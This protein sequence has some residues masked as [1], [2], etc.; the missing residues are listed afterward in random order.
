MAEIMQTIDKHKNMVLIGTAK[1]NYK[2]NEV[3]Y[4]D[5][6]QAVIESYGECKLTSA[7][8]VA[9]GFGVEN[10]FLINVKRNHDYFD[11]VT[12]LKHNDFTYIVPVNLF[13]SDGY[14]DAYH[15]NKRITYFQYILEEIG[16]FNDSTLIVTDKH[17]SL[18]EDLDG[19]IGEM[20]ELISQF[21]INSSKNLQGQNLI[22]VANNLANYP[23]AN[24]VLASAL[25]VCD[26]D[27]Y[28]TL[29]FGPAIFNIDTFD[30]GSELAFFKNNSIAETSIENLLN[31]REDGPQK[32]VTID[33]I[34]KYIK[35]EIDFSEFKGKLFTGYQKLR[36]EQK[37]KTFL[38]SLK[39]YII[40]DFRIE[41]ITSYQS[42][43]GT[44]VVL[45]RFDIWT[46][47][48]IEKCSI[49]IGVEV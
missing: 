31:F 21:H 23:L 14:N 1:T 39:G 36:I 4:F 11:I 25:C 19:F 17:A 47:H 28:P 43:P 18:Y 45:N 38:Q 33:R 35:R 49:G 8:K 20:E 6:I 16:G 2:L 26:L 24:V 5:T 13:M 41:S 3:T 37:L 27:S 32:I 15:D 9:K 29:A 7:F 22:F 10:I 46:V 34:V 40:E 44:V 30:V 12:T 48:S 42:D